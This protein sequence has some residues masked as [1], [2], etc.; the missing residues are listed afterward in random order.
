[1]SSASVPVYPCSHFPSRVAASGRPKSQQHKVLIRV[2]FIA[3][4]SF[5]IKS[6]YSYLD[7]DFLSSAKTEP[8]LYTMCAATWAKPQSFRKLQNRSLERFSKCSLV[9][10]LLQ[11]LGVPSAHMR[12]FRFLVLFVTIHRQINQICWQ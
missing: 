12:C 7:L 11:L 8:V 3:L 9:D 6:Q 5:Q 2:L 10:F 1:M 4:P